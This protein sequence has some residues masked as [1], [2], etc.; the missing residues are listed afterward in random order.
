MKLMKKIIVRVLAA[1]LA[2]IFLAYVGIIGWFI[3]NETSIV[4]HPDYTTRKVTSPPDSLNLNYS[5]VAL[6]TS[7]GETLKGWE[8]LA[9]ST[10]SSTTWILFFHGN[11]GNVSDMGYP[12]RYA[13]WAALGF[14]TLSVDYRGYGE[15]SGTPSEV[16][17][18][19]DGKTEYEYLTKT[20]GVKPSNIIIY[21]FSLGSGTATEIASNFP[22]KCLV[23]EG[24]FTSV[25]D[26]GAEIYPFLPIEKMATNKFANRLK[27]DKI[28]KPLLV[29]H[30]KDDAQIPFSH[31]KKLFEMAKE[32]KT[33]IELTGG[34]MNAQFVDRSKMY[35][36]LKKFISEN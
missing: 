14:N 16:G 25:P 23:L 30:S 34:H 21:G 15:S 4:F 5:P 6:K 8:I 11:A 1:L 3:A 26:V 29:L 35:D 18:Y 36:G 2:I 24:A 20:K 33:F 27:M 7:D 22:A 19:M 31:G 32:P 10:D 9:P 17:F 12:Q 28:N 13:G